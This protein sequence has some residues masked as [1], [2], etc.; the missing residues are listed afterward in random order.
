[1][2]ELQCISQQDQAIGLG[3]F[4]HQGRA[5]ALGGAQDVAP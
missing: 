1:V 3:H 2:A 5:R 4:R